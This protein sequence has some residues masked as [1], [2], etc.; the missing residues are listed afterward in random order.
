LQCGY[1]VLAGECGAGCA[2][3]PRQPV[4]VDAGKALDGQQLRRRRKRGEPLAGELEQCPV[5]LAQLGTRSGH[6]PAR[7]PRTQHRPHEH[8]PSGQR[9]CANSG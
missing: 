8:P 7:T 2:V 9:P 3:H 6:L 1:V 4:S 5:R